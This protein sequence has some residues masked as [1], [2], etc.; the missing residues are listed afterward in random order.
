MKRTVS[1]MEARKHLGELLEGVFYRN[2]EVV[3]ERAGKPMAVVIPAYLYENI[4]RGRDRLMEL[5]KMN[6]EHNKDV[7][8]EELEA[9][10]EAVMLELRPHYKSAAPHN[11][12]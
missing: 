1:A 6:W 10:I 8:P 9:D 11:A 2:D 12:D 4:E 5:I 7:P 3:I